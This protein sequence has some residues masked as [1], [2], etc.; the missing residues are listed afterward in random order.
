MTKSKLLKFFFSKNKLINPPPTLKCVREQGPV[1]DSSRTS[2]QNL[3]KSRTVRE[4]VHKIW[5]SHELFAKLFEGSF[6]FHE[7]A[8]L[9]FSD[10]FFHVNDENGQQ[11]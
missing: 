2:S 6:I 4:A 7:H 11:I 3:G 9:V 10:V 1:R 5:E 8:S